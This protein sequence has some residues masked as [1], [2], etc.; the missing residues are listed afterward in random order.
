M[1]RQYAMRFKSC[2]SPKPLCIWTETF[3]TLT[4]LV[5]GIH[6]LPTLGGR[7]GPPT[8]FGCLFLSLFH[9]MKLNYWGNKNQHHINKDNMYSLPLPPRVANPPICIWDLQE[10]ILPP[11]GL[12]KITLEIFQGHPDQMTIYFVEEKCDH[13]KKVGNPISCF[14]K[15]RPS[16]SYSINSHG[17]GLV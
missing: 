7:S 4:S 10:T 1:P 12:L 8:H 11:R 15:L 14:P 9:R 6:E 17:N 13:Q 5:C 3:W 16:S 2:L